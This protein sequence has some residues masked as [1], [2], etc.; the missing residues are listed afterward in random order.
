MAIYLS[1]TARKRSKKGKGLSLLSEQFTYMQAIKPLFIENKTFGEKS[2]ELGVWAKLLN[3]QEK[4]SS[5]SK[6]LRIHEPSGIS[7]DLNR[8]VSSSF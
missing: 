5:F 2:Q 6:L 1:K 8:F 7:P 4:F 3:T